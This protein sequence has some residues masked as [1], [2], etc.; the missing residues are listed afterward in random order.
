MP[1]RPKSVEQGTRMWQT[2]DGKTD[3]ATENNCSDRRNRLRAAACTKQLGY[4][5]KILVLLCTDIGERELIATLPWWRARDTDLCFNSI[6]VLHLDIRALYALSTAGKTTA[7]TG[8]VFQL[9]ELWQHSE[10]KNKRNSALRKIRLR[11]EGSNGP[12]SLHGC[13]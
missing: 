5:Y 3:H 11:W 6:A 13:S 9:A 4:A 2:T 1:C 8:Q 12:V 7:T 10:K